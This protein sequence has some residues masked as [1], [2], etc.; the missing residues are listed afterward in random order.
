M[1]RMVHSRLYNLAETGGK[2]CSEQ[3]G[4][5]KP[6]SCEDQILKIISDGFHRRRSPRP[7]T[8]WSSPLLKGYTNQ[9]DTT[10]NP[11]CPSGGEEPQTVR[12]WQQ[13]NPN[14]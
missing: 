4:F 10:I 3:A 9:L 12:H 7:A 14:A 1:K 2:L 6:R 5:R 13:W 11:K 8:I